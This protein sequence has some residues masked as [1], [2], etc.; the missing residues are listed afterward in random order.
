MPKKALLSI[1]NIG[2]Y[3][4]QNLSHLAVIRLYPFRGW[5]HIGKIHGNASLI[6]FVKLFLNNLTCQ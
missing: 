4:S 2:S 6:S 5:G 3:L 1:E